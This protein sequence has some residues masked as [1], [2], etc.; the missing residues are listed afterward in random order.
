M[1]LNTTYITNACKTTV[2]ITMAQ[3]NLC[4]L[5]STWFSIYSKSKTFAVIGSG[6]LSTC[7]FLVDGYET[8]VQTSGMLWPGRDKEVSKSGQTAYHCV[9]IATP[10]TQPLPRQQ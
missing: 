7:I 10:Q 4:P 8:M 9:A 3:Y 2:Y 6:F 5:I 1:I